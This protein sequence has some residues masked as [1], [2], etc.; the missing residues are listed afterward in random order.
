MDIIRDV[1]SGLVF[2]TF[3]DHKGNEIS[4]ETSPTNNNPFFIGSIDFNARFLNIRSRK[5][6][7]NLVGHESDT[8]SAF[9]LPMEMPL[10]PDH[11]TPTLY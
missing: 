6:V 5:F 1:E 8:N 9:F 7:Q 2:K 11:M 10:A 3:P 4:I